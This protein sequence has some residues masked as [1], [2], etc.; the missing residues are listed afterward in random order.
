MRL[1]VWA[2]RSAHLLLKTAITSRPLTYSLHFCSKTEDYLILD[3]TTITNLELVKVMHSHAAS[4]ETTLLATLDST[5]TPM[6]GRLLR[7]WML[8]PL[9][10]R[11][12]IIERQESVAYLHESHMRLTTLRDLLK[13]IGDMHRII[14]RITTSRATNPRDMLALKHILMQLPKLKATQD[15]SR[16]PIKHASS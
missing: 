11:D 2:L 16:Q 5:Q 15:A 8:R 6:G 9:N 7:E 14:S 12:Q 3:E 1:S 4:Q 10:R 13:P